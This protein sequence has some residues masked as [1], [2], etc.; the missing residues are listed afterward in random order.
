MGKNAKM[1]KRNWVK[2]RKAAEVIS[3]KIFTFSELKD[4][5]TPTTPLP[6]KYWQAISRAAHKSE[7]RQLHLLLER[8]LTPKTFET[9]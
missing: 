7:T 1:K 4:N 9:I 8:E 5:H 3:G 6:E 2:I